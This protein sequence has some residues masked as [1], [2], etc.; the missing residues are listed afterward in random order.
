VVAALEAKFPVAAEHLAK[1][2]ED[3]LAFVT[4]PRELW[5]QIWSN[6]PRSG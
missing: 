4:F 1:A 6:N 5:R 2:R 3:L